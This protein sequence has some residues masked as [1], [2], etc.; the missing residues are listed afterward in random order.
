MWLKSLRLHKYQVLFA[1]MEY[2]QMLTITE[3]YLTDQVSTCCLHVLVVC[4]CT[5]LPGYSTC[6]RE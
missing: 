2:E 5:N 3:D 6:H 1:D 4:T